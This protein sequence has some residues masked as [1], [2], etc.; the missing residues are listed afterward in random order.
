M[1]GQ[2]KVALD[3]VELF[4]ERVG[5]GPPLLT[6]HGGLGLDH[7]YLRSW[8]DPLS[9]SFELIYFDQR[10]NG[11]SGNGGSLANATHATWVADIEALRRKLGLEK[12]VLFGHSYGSFLAL[13]YAIAH[14]ENLAGL[15]LCEVAP[16]IDYMPVAFGRVQE[17]SPELF[18]KLMASFA[19]PANDDADLRAMWNDILPAYFW[20]FDP[21]VAAKMDAPMQYRA[22][23][24]NQSAGKCLPT[25]DVTDTVSKI[26]APTLVLAGRHDWLLPV[27]EGA[28]RVHDA[29]PSSRMVVFEESGHFPFIEEP[30][31]FLDAL[32]SWKA[33][34]L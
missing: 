2:M 31:A 17:R 33:S 18:A 6:L 7:T 22:E 21:E 28:K 32:R 25:F 34:V 10:G 19:R 1:S 26:T 11:R 3:D 24:F 16:K 8:L 13:E 4:C 5:S 23:A 15:V 30:A 27:E 29:I 12:F 14:P 9:D 20:K